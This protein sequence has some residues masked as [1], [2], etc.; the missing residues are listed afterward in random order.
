[1]QGYINFMLK[2]LHIPDSSELFYEI[3]SRHVKE[4]LIWGGQEHPR[5]QEPNSVTF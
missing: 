5:K 1:M 4:L 2:A 3:D